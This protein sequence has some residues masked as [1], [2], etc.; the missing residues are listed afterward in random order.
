MFFVAAGYHL[1]RDPPALK[2][3][4]YKQWFDTW[5]YIIPCRFCRESYGPFFDHLD[6]EQYFDKK[7]GLIEF[8]YDMKNL[9]N[10]KLRSQEFTAAL[11]KYEELKRSEPLLTQDEIAIKLRELSKTFHTKDAPPLRD[12]INKYMEHRVDC[13][14]FGEEIHQIHKQ[15]SDKVLG[16]ISAMKASSPWPSDITAS[17]RVTLDERLP[18]P[19]K[20]GGGLRQ[21]KDTRLRKSRMRVS[22]RKRG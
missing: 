13:D 6:I 8:V 22:S 18:L 11:E 7:F 20:Q 9:V 19:P 3:P 14:S 15:R 21:R 5:R 2:N 17:S 10:A 4:V 16:R 12:V 1:N